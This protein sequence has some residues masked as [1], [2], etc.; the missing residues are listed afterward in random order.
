M[1]EC[2]VFN[3]DS[4]VSCPRGYSSSEAMTSTTHVLVGEMKVGEIST[5]VRILE[6][7]GNRLNLLEKGF[8]PGSEVRLLR[9]GSDD[10]TYIVLLDG[11]EVEITAGESSFIL[12]T[13]R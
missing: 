3:P 5:V 12:T 6:G 2:P 4:G 11:Y 9:R 8:V 1:L 13:I 7:A 10:L